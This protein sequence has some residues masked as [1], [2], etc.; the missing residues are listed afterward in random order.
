[1]CSLLA[2]IAIAKGAPYFMLVNSDEMV[3][4]PVIDRVLSDGLDGYI[5]SRMDFSPETGRDLGMLFGGQGCWIFRTE[6][7]QRHG[8]RI[9]PYIVGEAFVD[10]ILTTKILCHGRAR[11]FNR[12]GEFVR[13]EA[14]PRLWPSSPFLNYTRYLASLD[15]LYLGIWH[16]YIGRLEKL[17]NA[18]ASE[19]VEYALQE[20][21]FHYQPS[22]RARLVQT[23]RA[24]KAYFRFR[25]QALFNRSRRG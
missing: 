25:V 18:N 20:E 16:E 9:R 3:M 2:E 15:S 13:H 7:W 10:T 8:W 22:I 1:M 23:G 12:S 4:Q 24:S 14:H 11:L 5:F 19:V 6:W 17:R 21:V